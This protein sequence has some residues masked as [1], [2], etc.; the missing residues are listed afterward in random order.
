MIALVVTEVSL[1]TD[2]QTDTN[3][4]TYSSKYFRTPYGG[5]VKML[6]A[7]SV[8]SPVRAF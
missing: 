4:H 8:R 3:T 1:R 7:W 2:R 5:E 6:L